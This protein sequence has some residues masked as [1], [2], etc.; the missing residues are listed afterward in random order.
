[1]ATTNSRVKTADEIRELI[2][3]NWK[4]SDINATTRENGINFNSP[5]GLIFLADEILGY[6]YEAFNTNIQKFKKY[7]IYYEQI[8]GMINNLGPVEMTT[9]VNNLADWFNYSE[10]KG[11]VFSP[12]SQWISDDKV[13][14][15][16]LKSLYSAFSNGGFESLPDDLKNVYARTMKRTM[17]YYKILINIFKIYD[18]KI[19]KR[20][21]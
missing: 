2:K 5:V 16:M 4:V 7:E 19:F 12:I 18:S 9:E 20:K 6:Y 14:K 1:M 13:T 8:D 11:D 21:Q 15:D 17:T 10:F 3:D